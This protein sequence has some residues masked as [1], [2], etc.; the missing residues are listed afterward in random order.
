MP[1]KSE[2]SIDFS[3]KLNPDSATWNYLKWFLCLTS[4]RVKDAVMHLDRSNKLIW[5]NPEVLRNLWFA[6]SILGQNEKWISIL[7]RAQYISPE[8]TLITED[9]AIALIWSG[10]VLEWNALLRQVRK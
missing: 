9:L 7:K 1:E 8:D 2:K 3:L 10:E 6:Y 4:D 5:N